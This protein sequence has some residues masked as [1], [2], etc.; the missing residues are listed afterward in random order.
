MSWTLMR[1]TNE[2]REIKKLMVLVN[3]VKFV[4][5]WELC[6]VSVLKQVELIIVPSF[7]N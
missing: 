5:S 6:I 4:L 7:E 1:N 3:S 2:E